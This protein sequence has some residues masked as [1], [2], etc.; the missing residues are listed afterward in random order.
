[1]LLM[2]EQVVEVKVM[3]LNTV[4]GAMLLKVMVLVVLMIIV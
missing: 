1:M 4:V 2:R 3:V